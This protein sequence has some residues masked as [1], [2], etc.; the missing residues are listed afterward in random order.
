[1]KVLGCCASVQGTSEN[2]FEQS[3]RRNRDAAYCVD[4][5]FFVLFSSIA[6]IVMCFKYV[7][8]LSPTLT[9][10]RQSTYL[11]C[12]YKSG[13]LIK[14]SALPQSPAPLSM[15][16]RPLAA[17]SP[18]LPCPAG[19]ARPCSC[20]HWQEGQEGQQGLLPS[21][22]QP[23]RQ[24]RRPSR[25]CPRGWRTVRVCAMKLKPQQQRCTHTL[26]RSPPRANAAHARTSQSWTARRS[27]PV[28]AVSIS[29]AAAGWSRGTMCPDANT[30]RYVSP[31]WLRMT[32]AGL[33]GLRVA[34]D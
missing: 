8:K 24:A 23:R 3:K 9:T 29:R 21:S 13:L 32:P 15:T 25:A 1:M 27:V 11:S 12:L 5:L 7:G 4:R 33:C 31:P 17:Q 18:P 16:W 14:E 19:L 28:N 30:F 34:L 2:V 26:H 20:C 10:Q 22:P 6:D